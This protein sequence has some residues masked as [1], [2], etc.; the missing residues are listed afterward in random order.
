[1]SKV[2]LRFEGLDELKAQLRA[3]PKELV[4]DASSIVLTAGNEVVDV[5][6]AVY[7]DHAHVGNLRRGLTVRPVSAGPYGTGALVRSAAKHAWL[8]EHGSQ[9][10][11]YVTKNG[12]KHLTGRMPPSHIF[13]R[14]MIQKRRAMYGKFRELL[15]AHGLQVTGDGL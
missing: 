9:A 5:V 12:K 13:I 14:T 4:D 2:T 15:V 6:A 7:E 3:L 8:F 11:H 10:R 1:V